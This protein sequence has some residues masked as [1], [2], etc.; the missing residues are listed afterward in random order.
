LPAHAVVQLTGLPFAAEKVEDT[1]G[2]EGHAE[3]DVHT[4]DDG[5]VSGQ[6][7]GAEGENHQA[8]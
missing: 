3:A 5:T 1:D 6:R 8:E 7:P 4:G 2:N